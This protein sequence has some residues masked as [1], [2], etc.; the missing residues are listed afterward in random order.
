[1]DQPVQQDPMQKAI[2]KEVG[3]Y[4]HE[5]VK[6][7]QVLSANHLAFH[8]GLTLG[9]R[10]VPDIFIRDPESPSA[11]QLGDLASGATEVYQRLNPL[12]GMS[13]QLSADMLECIL[14]A[15]M[16]AIRARNLKRIS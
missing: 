2:W 11:S 14:A 6:R 12:L 7:F 10:A 1:M 5:L 4:E 8:Q 16:L 13:H 15:R 3:F 9:C